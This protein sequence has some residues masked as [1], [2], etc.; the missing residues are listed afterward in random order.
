MFASVPKFVANAG[1]LA[2]SA[3]VDWNLPAKKLLF[4]QKARLELLNGVDLLADAVKVTLGPMG[5]NVMLERASGAPTVTKDGFTV[6]REIAIEDRIRDI[7]VQMVKAVAENTADAAGDGTT[8][9][10]VLAQA[11]FQEGLRFVAA[12]MDPM[13]LKRG[14][15]KAATSAMRGLKRISMPCQDTKAIAQVATISA[16]SDDSVGRLLAEAMETV[17][18]EGVVTI[19]EGASIDDRIEFVEGMQFDRGYL[20]PFFINDE[21]S[22][23]AR[24]D[25]PY[26]LLCAKKCSQVRELLPL[27]GLVAESGKPLLLIAEDF[28]SEVLALLVVNG[29][30]GVIRVAA[31]KAPGFG[32]R[33]TEMLADIAVVT[34]GTVISETTGLMLEKTT[35]ENLGSAEQIRVSKDSTTIVDGGGDR[36]SIDARSADIRRQ[37]EDTSSDYDRDKLEERLAK[38]TGGVAIIKVGAPSEI[39]MK[40]KKSRV[41]DALHAARAAAE[42]GIVPGGGVALIRVCT[43]IEATITDND[44]QAAGVRLLLRAAEEPFRQIVANGGGDPAVALN[45]V[46]E[47]TGSFGYNAATMEFGDLVKMGVIDPT[48]VT[49]LPLQNAVSVAGLLL[50]IEV[51]VTSG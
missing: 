13:D 3:M 35:L 12:G 39:E 40:E 38:L 51:A 10:T 25:E 30:R 43:D 17:G 36:K 4:A 14:I 50:T 22:M 45:T 28:S 34:G 9:A 23:S 7:G 29:L 20:S 31:I 37:I 24:L 1:N 26:I 15:D 11:I 5:R 48:K 8:T 27:L 33:R 41:E 44:D 42:E 18:R 2:D 16:N 46:K 47:G 19:E 6:A 32:D 49:R 21:D